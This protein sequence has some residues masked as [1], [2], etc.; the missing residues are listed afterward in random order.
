M[1]TKTGCKRKGPNPFLIQGLKL[2]RPTLQT[3][4]LV[5]FIMNYLSSGKTPIDRL[6]Y[7]IEQ[8][9]VTR[10]RYIK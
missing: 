7:F 3:Q 9:V 6:I 5:V 8:N 2:H 10:F 1:I 4:F